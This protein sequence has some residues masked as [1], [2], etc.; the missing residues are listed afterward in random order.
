VD[1]VTRSKDGVVRRASVRYHNAAESGPRLSDRAVR[2]LVRL[3]NVED[4]YFI[5]DMSEFERLMAELDKKSETVDPVKLVKGSDGLFKVKDPVV[6]PVELSCG[7]CCASHCAMNVHNVAGTVIGVTLA[8]KVNVALSMEEFE[9][10]H[11]YERDLLDDYEEDVPVKSGCN[12]TE[13]KDEL[14]DIITAVE[15][16]FGLDA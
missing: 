15:T 8:H 12:M 16:D 3:F 9:F 4:T 6:N 2:S 13:G 11:I 1:S 7:C 5:D 14:F 10:P